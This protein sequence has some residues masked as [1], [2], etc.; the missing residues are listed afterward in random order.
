M[1]IVTRLTSTA[2]PEVPFKAS[3]IGCV[4]PME[5]LNAPPEL[6]DAL[7]VELEFDLFEMIVVLRPPGQNT[8]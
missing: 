7:E 3:R 6:G 2:T 4:R 8:T 5:G 1:T